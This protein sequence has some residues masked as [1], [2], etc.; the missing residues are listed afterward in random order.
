MP[1]ARHILNN[2]LIAQRYFFP[3]PAL[4]RRPTLIP[5]AGGTL[6]AYWLVNDP[7][8]PTLVHFHGNAECVADYASSQLMRDFSALGF[9]CFF[10]E[11][12]GSGGC[13]LQPLL[14]NLLD[15]VR[16]FHDYLIGTDVT[17]PQVLVY[18]RSVGSI[19]ALEWIHRFPNTGGLILESAV[20]DVLERLLMRIDPTEIGLSR[21]QLEDA[22]D[23]LLNHEHKLLRY[24][25]PVLLMHARHDD[26][27]NPAHARQLR[28]WCRNAAS[29]LILFN[30]G[31][32]NSLYRQN[33]DPFIEAIHAYRTLQFGAYA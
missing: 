24:P 6:Q 31:D 11:Y 9:N 33:R 4:I 32:H 27:V 5:I 3:N 7:A 17:D 20:A 26:L 12:R 15:D 19:F 25:N 29:R 30:H 8:S 2:P 22:C 28:R 23:E 1:S 10:A 16:A 21:E 14:A 18:G 13:N